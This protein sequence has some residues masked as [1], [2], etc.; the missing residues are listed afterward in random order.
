MDKA[1]QERLEARR[2]RLM[3]KQYYV[4]TMTARPMQDPLGELAPLLT[5]HLDF[6]D[7][8]ESRGILFGAGP[9]RHEDGNWDGSGMAIV[10]AASIAEA[11][12]IAEAE[13]FHKA[14]LRKNTVTGWQLNEGS[15]GI[16]LRLSAH[17]FEFD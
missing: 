8:L 10:R 15:V 6:I 9:F 5:E 7:D 14:G 11:C 4:I 16:H 1:T 13:P 17:R 2:A 12:A 3:R